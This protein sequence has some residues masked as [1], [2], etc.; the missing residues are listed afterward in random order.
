[1]NESRIGPINISLFWQVLLGF[2]TDLVFEV[3][4]ISILSK[5]SMPSEAVVRRG[6][7]KKVLLEISENSQE[8]TCARDFLTKLQV[9]IF[10]LLYATNT[11]QD[12]GSKYPP[13]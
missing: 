11:K 8:N 2:M 13:P 5:Y 9:G 6:S 7:V 4:Q 1:M 10:F 3:T 12:L